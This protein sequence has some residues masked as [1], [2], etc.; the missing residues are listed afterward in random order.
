MIGWTITTIG[1]Y[2]SI[3]NGYA[4]KST[5]YIPNGILNFR[6]TN[7]CWDGTINI[8]DD[9]EFLPS[10]FQKLYRQYLLNEGDILFV[11][12]GATRGKI[13]QISR[14]I[15]PALMNQNMWRIV[16][17][18]DNLN[19]EFLYYYLKNEIEYLF[20]I[21]EDQA[22]GFFKK[23]DFRNI[24]L[25]L[26]P[27]P[28]QRKIAYI[29]NTIQQAIEKQEQLIRITIELKK[30]LMQKLFT[31]GLSS[32][33]QKQT[34]IGLV[35]ESWEVM[36]VGNIAE[37][38]SGGTPSRTEKK[39]WEN[40]TIP[41]IKTGEVKYCIINKS[42]EK[43]TEEGYKNSS[44][45]LC[46][47]GTLLMAMYGQGVTR[48]KVA[49]L[50]IDATINQACA[51]IIPKDRKKLSTNFLYYFFEKNYEFIRN[52]GHGANQKNLSG[53]LIKSL[54]FPL[55]KEIG[56]QIEIAR[57][58]EIFDKKKEVFKKKKKTLTALFK[59]MLHQLMTGQ[60]RVNEI[61]FDS[62]VKEYKL[63]EEPLSM[64]AE[65]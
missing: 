55:P 16:P 40:G 20:Q 60:I 35:P 52:Y 32:E 2:C 23:N 7:I 62:M 30:A 12:V 36:K 50:G 34:E 31:E 47:K 11:M 21:G 42:E 22:R 33:K 1:E 17:F 59:T 41:W 3:S 24:P 61:K 56:E 26:P 29:L 6:V 45:R 14:N 44:A 4:F 9:I 19:K 10:S 5:D 65:V 54:E 63:I 27:L 51:A 49:I 13:V 53:A 48:G 38:N 58:L 8:V 28:E 25:N 15:L 43:I 37:V 57:T 64:V 18:D 39:Y 46:K